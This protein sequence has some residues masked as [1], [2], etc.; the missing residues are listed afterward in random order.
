MNRAAEDPQTF[1]DAILRS[2]SRKCLVVAGP[3]TGK[4]YLFRQ[5]LETNPED[6]PRRLILTFINNLANELNRELGHLSLVYTFHAHAHLLLRRHQELR[7]NLKADFR[8]FPKLV[9][10]IKKDWETTREGQA[11]QFV[12]LMRNL[13]DGASLE[14]YVE[15]GDYYQAVSYDDSVFRLYKGASGTS[16]SIPQYDL[17]LV[18]EYQDFNRLEV[19]LIELYAAHNRVLIVGD[20]DQ[21][22]Y[23][24]LR[25]S[26]PRYIR[27]L[28]GRGDYETFSL[29]Y[30]MR[31]T[32]AIVG[33]VDDVVQGA[34]AAGSLQER[35]EK[36]YLYCAPAKQADS[37]AYPRVR[38]VETTVQRLG[39]GNYFGRYVAEKIEEIPV[40]EIQESGE[41]GFPTVLVIAS[42]PYRWQVV[43]HLQLQGYTVET[44][45]EDEPPD[46]GRPDAFRILREEPESNLG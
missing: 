13:E 36:P 28:Y 2:G 18:D 11:P 32:E 30:C 23:S 10:L 41:G 3:G 35:I 8:Y 20:D 19:A 42:N 33:A 45:E 40:G 34:R 27:E 44:T 37:L 43:Q 38:L 24:Q 22:L 29:P 17:V 4:T 39:K 31:C 12:A 5:I 7:G 16:A 46:L 26:D 25:G 21:T 14:F 6:R 9:H 15:R 1:I